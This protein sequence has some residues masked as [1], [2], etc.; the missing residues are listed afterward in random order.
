M[1]HKISAF[2]QKKKGGGGGGGYKMCT[3]CG[4]DNESSSAQET[5]FTVPIV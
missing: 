3:R 2:F 1:D 4:L 5:N